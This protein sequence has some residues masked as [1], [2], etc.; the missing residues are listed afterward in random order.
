MSI[1]LPEGAT[2]D[3]LGNKIF[4]Q[5]AEIKRLRAALEFYRD[6]VA[7]KK[8]HDPN[9]DIQIPDFYSE[10]SFGDTAEVALTVGQPVDKT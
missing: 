9:N 6:P 5:A 8:K 4:A 2:I 7:W 3:D 1:I 10:T